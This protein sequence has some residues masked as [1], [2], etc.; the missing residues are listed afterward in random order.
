M[1]FPQLD[2]GIPFNP[3]LANAFFLSGYIESWGRGIEKIAQ[4]CEAYGIESPDYDSG[5]SGLM[6]TF[7]ASA[8]YLALIN[9]KTAEPGFDGTSENGVG[10]MLKRYRFFL[11][12][13]CASR[14]GGN[15]KR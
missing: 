12:D 3:L 11:F 7:H 14:L 1:L 8:V 4:E 10:K 13:I 2:F 9:P 15:P 6:L 5:M